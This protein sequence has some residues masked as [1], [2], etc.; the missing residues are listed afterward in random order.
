MTD[1]EFIEAFEGGRLTEFH[2]RD[3]LRLAW[4]RV[5]RAGAGAEAAVSFD[6]RRFAAAAGAGR[7]YHETLTVFWVRLVR[8]ADAY[9]RPASFDELLEACP[10]LLDPLAPGRH[11]RAETLWSEVARGEWIK[12][13]LLPVPAV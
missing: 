12:P 10:L 5:R 3:H 13:D 4:L 1:S 8:H 6:I 11:W 7:K 2:H 9:F